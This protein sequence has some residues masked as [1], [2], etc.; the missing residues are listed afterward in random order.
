MKKLFKTSSMIFVAI[1]LMV[2]NCTDLEEEP[3][4]RF[5]PESFFKSPADANVAL[6]GAYRQ[7]ATEKLYGRKLVTTLMLRGDM[8]DIGNLATPARRVDHNIFNVGAD[9]GMNTEIWPTS[10]QA[11]SAANYT[12]FGAEQLDQSDPQVI[13]FIAEAR[14]VRAF[15]YFHLVRLFGDIPYIGEAIQDPLA[16]ADLGKT[17]ASVVY[18][19]IIEDLEFAA[20]NLPDT[21]FAGA[22]S[23]AGKGAAYGFLALVHLTLGNW[24]EAYDNAKVV[25]DNRGIFATGLAANYADN[26]D[27]SIADGFVE[28]LFVADFVNATDGLTNDFMGPMT[29]I[30]GIVPNQNPEEKPNA[31][32][33]SVIVPSQAVF[34]SW[35]DLDYR[36][37]A[38]FITEGFDGDGN[39]V[40]TEGFAPAF[41]VTR[42]HIRKY[43]TKCGVADDSCQNSSNNY[44]AMRF[45]EVLLIAAEALNELGGSPSEIAGY[46]NELRAR[47]RSADGTV[48]SFPPDLA[49][50]GQ[51]QMRDS[52][53]EERRL[54]LAFE[55]KRWYDIKR[56]EIGPEVFAPGSLEPQPNFNPSRD[57]ILPLP[58]TEID[59][60]PNLL[61]Q[62]PGY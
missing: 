12:I 7:I 40:G 28:H 11:I 57:Y 49:A 54:E 17:S 34:D 23:R 15:T 29:G 52:I 1:A 2:T 30:N 44:I 5:S 61:P 25:L 10:Y 4:G 20:Q 50:L 41:G 21:P 55:F 27:A 26:F 53:R 62:N 39:L 14:F 18:E 3:V 9:N 31:P 43:F 38:S 46:I 36:K 47:A 32:G 6:Q 45:G 8:C 56:W 51:S 60:N 58:Q 22:K 13:E 42:P 16:V 48:R 35:N 59:Q 24:Q 19:N 33:W 37:E